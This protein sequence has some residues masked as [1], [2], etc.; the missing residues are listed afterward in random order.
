MYKKT[1]FTFLSIKL[2]TTQHLIYISQKINTR[3]RRQYIIKL[4]E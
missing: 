1:V 4:R 3:W 2:R